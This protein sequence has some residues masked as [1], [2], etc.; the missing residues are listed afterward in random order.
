TAEPD[1]AHSYVFAG[2]N[3]NGDL[4]HHD[5]FQ[6][7]EGYTKYTYTATV[8]GTKYIKF[9]FA[10]A[11][12]LSYDPNGGTYHETTGVTEHTYGYYNSGIA[13]TEVPTAANANDY[14]TGWSLYTNKNTA[15]DITI[16]AN[17]IVTYNTSDEQNPKL[18]ISW[19]NNS[20]S[21]TLDAS[22]DSGIMLVANY[23]YKQE[24]IAVT[25]DENNTIDN[26]GQ[27]G[28]IDIV[29]STQM[30]AVTGND[31]QKSTAGDA[32]D[33]ITVSAAAKIGYQFDGWFETL[34]GS[35]VSKAREYSYIVVGDTTIYAKF[36]KKTVPEHTTPTY[37]SSYAYIYGYND[38]TMGPENYVLRGEVSAML[39][40]TVKQNN[41][42][43][44]FQYDKSAKPPFEDIG[45]RWDRSAIEFMTHKKAFNT[46]V[47]YVYPREA[48]TR[49]EAC[50]LV[51]LG[52]GFTEDETLTYEEYALILNDSKIKG[53]SIIVGYDDYNLGLGDKLLRAQFCTMFNRILGRAEAWLTTKSGETITAET[54]GFRD[55][56]K[57]WY[58]EDVLRATSSYDED[59][60]VDMSRRTSKFELDDLV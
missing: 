36:S 8:D 2:A 44:D 38:A 60:Y 16:P 26:D 56:P 51:C 1:T 19:N 9:L 25:Y 39:H 41:A 47:P 50:K 6:A 46:S 43:G 48:I 27:G 12:F 31:T 55:L 54:Y 10:K 20:E 45:G 28:K 5:E 49:G 21:V 42:L 34:D 30:Q 53:T 7:N 14:F 37:Q 22:A 13:E 23:R 18:T 24:A 35:A 59:G 57:E 15:A 52:L 17:H 58:Y 33:I 4:I 11:G 40:R 29:N 32:G 3:I